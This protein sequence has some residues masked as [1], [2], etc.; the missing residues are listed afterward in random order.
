MITNRD[1]MVIEFL[2][3]F[4]I[5]STNTISELFYPSLR[6][7]QNRLLQMVKH[8]EIKRDRD[9]FTMEYCYYIKKPKQLKH[10]L[11]LTNFYR[12]LH[13][14]GCNILQFENEVT[15]G[16]LRSD[17]FVIFK[18][19]EKTYLN[20]IEVQI[21]N[22]KL[23]TEKYRTLLISG[24]YKDYGL[25]V[26]PRLIAITNKNVPSIDKYKLIKINEDMNNISDIL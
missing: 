1:Y 4:K 19:K 17:G 22:N 10:S 9:N 25:P 21:S 2:H 15:M 11:L 3:K 23:D 5:A 6:V 20:F 7:A 14:S 16:D 26:F 12:E 8:K 24:K 13:K 18:H